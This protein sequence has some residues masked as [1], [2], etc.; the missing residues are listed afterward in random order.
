MGCTLPTGVHAKPKA[1]LFLPR[2]SWPTRRLLDVPGRSVE[3]P[4]RASAFEDSPP[5]SPGKAVFCPASPALRIARSASPCD[6]PARASTAPSDCSARSGTSTDNDVLESRVATPKPAAEQQVNTSSANTSHSLPELLQLWK[7]NRHSREAL[8][9]EERQCI[10]GVLFNSMPA[11]RVK[12][13][14]VRRLPPSHLMHRFCQEEQESLDRE[15]MQQRKHKE[16]MLLH[17]TRWEYAPLIEENGLD[18]T[19]GHLSTGTWLG[20]LAEKAH[21]YAIKGPGP[22]QEDGTRLF[23]LFAVACVPNTHD[24]DDERSFG[25]WRIQSG[26]RMCPAYA[27][28]YSA[29]MNIKG[30][31]QPPEPR[32]N[33]LTMARLRSASPQCSDSSVEQSP[34]RS[35]LLRQR[36]W[37]GYYPSATSPALKVQTSPALKV[38]RPS[39][40]RSKE[41]RSPSGSPQLR[42]RSADP[43]LAACTSPSLKVHQESCHVVSPKRTPRHSTGNSPSASTSPSLEVCKNPRKK[44]KGRAADD[45]N[46]RPSPI[47]AT[48]EVFV[49]EKWIPFRPGSKLKDHPG[50]EQHMVHG[51]FWYLLKFDADGVSGSQKNTHTGK[52]R[53]LRRVQPSLKAEQPSLPAAPQA[54]QATSEPWKEVDNTSLHD[55]KISKTREVLH[56]SQGVVPDSKTLAADAGA[57]R[58]VLQSPANVHTPFA[59]RQH[60][61]AWYPNLLAHGVFH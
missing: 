16:F 32:M 56:Q 12:I 61:A 25:V 53:S 54:S 26:H 9:D 59:M 6:S 52:V 15:Q 2:P 57:P 39:G 11:E 46:D 55:S 43:Q 41:S 14:D 28:V 19:C 35:P 33:K 10:E 34:A 36:S 8:S 47:E 17:G 45:K 23:A 5:A 3:V 29:Q 58:I 60:M 4:G 38:H 51:Q 27:I 24:G 18:P 44:D 22:E 49:D 40:P 48:W 50:T 21:S 7:A 31:Q 1:T 13:V 20:G 30:K 37:D 42:P